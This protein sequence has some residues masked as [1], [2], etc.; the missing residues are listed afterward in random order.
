MFMANIELRFPLLG[1]LGVGGGYYGV[2]P[3]EVALFSDAGVAYWGQDLAYTG[4]DDRVWFLGGDRRPLVSAGAGLRINL[5]GFAIIELD[6]AY[7][8][9]R[10]RWIWQFGFTPGF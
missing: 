9:Q 4:P 2:L 5:L 7:A 8:F 1:A 3:V 10:D 6:Y